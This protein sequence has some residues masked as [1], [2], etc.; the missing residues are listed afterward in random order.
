M[1]FYEESTTAKNSV[2]K[3]CL[4]RD[5]GLPAANSTGVNKF[6]LWAE[7]SLLFLVKG[8]QDGKYFKRR[9]L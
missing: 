7:L 2:R 4:H 5:D 1:H 8:F 9:R 3:C 6:S